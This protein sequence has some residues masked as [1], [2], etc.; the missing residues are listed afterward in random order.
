M[1]PTAAGGT[2]VT[3]T[4]AGDTYVTSAAAAALDI[5]VTPTAAGGTWVIPTAFLG[6]YVTLAAPGDTCSDT[7]CTRRHIRDFGCGCSLRHLCDSNCS[8]RHLGSFHYIH[9]GT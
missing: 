4:A 9:R 5:C 8:W 6:T 1:T 7:D 3:P 2:Y